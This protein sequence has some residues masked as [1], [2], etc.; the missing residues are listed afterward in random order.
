MLTGALGLSALAFGAVGFAA[1][2]LSAVMLL[3]GL[4]GFLLGAGSSGL[5]ALAAIFYPTSIR[6]TGVGWA[7]GVGRFGSFVGPL[8]ATILVGSHWSIESLY[9]A[10]SAPGLIAAFF[11]LLL[12]MQQTARRMRQERLAGSG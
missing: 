5:I 6:S 1:P 8:V 10:L 9:L 3:E 2:S 4:G 7:N 12:G 11:V